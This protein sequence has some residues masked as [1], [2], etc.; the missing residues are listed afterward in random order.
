MSSKTN[1]HS[2]KVIKRDG[3]PQDINYTKINNR[4]AFLC[5]GELRDKTIIGDNLD[6][7]YDKIVIDVISTI[8]D[9]ITTQL[10]SGYNAFPTIPHDIKQHMGALQGHIMLD[11]WWE[12]VVR[13]IRDQGFDLNRWINVT[14]LNKRPDGGEITNSPMDQTFSESRPYINWNHHGSVEVRNWTNKLI[15]YINL[16][17]DKKYFDIPN[18]FKSNYHSEMSNRE[19]KDIL[20][21]FEKSNFGIIL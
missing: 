4:I 21:N 16:I 9:G 17:L 18:L 5:K 10:W 20:K 19:Q 15:E 11:D 2:Y 14:I 7:C 1:S 12:H 6:L 13:P 3:T 8:K